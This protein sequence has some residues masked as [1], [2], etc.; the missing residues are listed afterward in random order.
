[1]QAAGQLGCALIAPGVSGRHLLISHKTR[2]RDPRRW[3][4]VRWRWMG[5][6]Q[7]LPD[8]GGWGNHEFDKRGQAGS[9]RRERREG[10]ARRPDLCQWTPAQAKEDATP[11]SPLW[12]TASSGMAL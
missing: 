9:S 6:Q 8:V 7:Q 10:N 4:Y 1:M 5:G 11:V 2:I 12:L 3:L